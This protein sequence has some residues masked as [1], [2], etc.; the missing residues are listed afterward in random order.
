MKEKGKF[1]DDNCAFQTPSLSVAP[2]SAHQPQHG[3]PMGYFVGQTPPPSSIHTGP[4]QVIGQ[5]GQMTDQTGALV[6]SLPIAST[7]CSAAPSRINELTNSVPPLP[8]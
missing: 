1:V 7:P 3:M 2:A 5:T 6:V 4:V 8:S